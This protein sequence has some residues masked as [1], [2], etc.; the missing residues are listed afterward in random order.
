MNP[1]IGGLFKLSAIGFALLITITAYW[2]IWAASGLA[3]RQDNARLVYRQLQIKRGLIYASDGHTVLATNVKRHKNGLDIFLRAYP[4]GPLFGHPVGYNTVGSGRSGLELS[5]NDYLTAS[6]SDL[7]T[8]LGNIGDRLQGQT[9]TGNNIVTSLSVAAQRA[10]LKGLTGH[11]GAVVAIEPSTGRVLAMAST[12]TYNPNTVASNFTKLSSASR[13][14]PLLNRA[15]QGLY[16]PGSTFKVV[17]AT[18]A[19]ESGKFTPQTLIDGHGSCLTNVQGQPLCNAGGE[20]AGVVSLTDALT[21]SYNTVFAQVGEKVGVSRLYS[22]MDGFGF[23]TEPPLDYP[24]DEMQPSGLYTGGH[25]L[26]RSA[27]VDI[28]RVAIGQE[29]LGVTPLQMAEVVATVANHG[30]RMRPTLVDRVTSPGG[31]T[32]T[33]THPDALTRVM[34]PTTA[35][36]LNDMMRRVVE[37]GTGQEANLGSLSVAGKTGTAETGV[38][39][40]NTA[41]F[42]AFA[43]AENPRIAIA[44]V[45]EHTPEFGGTISAPIARDVITAYLGNS[46]AK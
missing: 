14:S 3:A 37:E 22:T 43:P 12:P 5:E 46:V 44:V 19:L 28:A 17:T 6:N 18:A 38:S 41:W 2:Q 7:S 35:S 42:I 9:V 16:A 39:G 33:T 21:F 1:R 40:L 23:F 13:G 25:L 34:S 36:E 11:D 27:P 26:R 15:T 8:V 31:A 10:A 4:F 30:L 45:I 24:S 29:R 20:S 32:V